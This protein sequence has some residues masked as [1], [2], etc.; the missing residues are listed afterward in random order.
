MRQ[1]EIQSKARWNT[2]WDKMKYSQSL[3]EIYIQCQDDGVRLNKINTHRQD[4]LQ[5]ETR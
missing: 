4:K 3:D 5:I 1:D 2:V